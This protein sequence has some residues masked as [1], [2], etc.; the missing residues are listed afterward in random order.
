M[1]RGLH[2]K[3]L[4]QMPGK[5]ASR[6]VIRERKPKASSAQED[7]ES[8]H[9]TIDIWASAPPAAGRTLGGYWP[10]RRGPAAGFHMGFE[11]SSETLS[12]LRVVTARS[13]LPFD[14]RIDSFPVADG[15]CSSGLITLA[16][17]RLNT[18]RAPRVA[19]T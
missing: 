5:T 10:R 19:N 11:A 7:N 9:R 13:R 15:S 8:T 16:N 1:G 18:P 12:R 17:M 3:N 6:K 4:S 2:K 14:R